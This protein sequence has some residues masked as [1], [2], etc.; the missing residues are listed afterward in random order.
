MIKTYRSIDDVLRSPWADLRTPG[1]KPEQ[2][3]R[4]LKSTRLEDSIYADLRDGDGALDELEAASTSKLKT[5]PALSRDVYQSL[6]SLM[7]RK[8]PEETLSATARKFN[9]NILDHVMEGDDYPTLKAVCEGRELPAYEAA[10]EFTARVA[11]E[12]DGL[13]ADMGGGKGALN[14]LEKLEDARE[15]AEQELSALLDRL[16]SGQGGNDTL[17]QTVVAAANHADS[18]QRQAEAVAKRVDTCMAKNKDAIDAVLTH[19]AHAAKEKAEEVQSVIGA[20]SE[21]P[22]NQGRNALNT[23]LLERVRKNPALLEISKYLGR[24]REIFAQGKKNG[25]AYG[26]GEK[27]SLEL[28][29][30]LSRAIT[31]ELALLAAPETIP[32]FLRKFQQKQLKQYRRREPIYKGAGD[33]ICCLDESSSTKGNPAAWGKAVAMTLLEIAADGGRKFAL[34]HFSGRDS[35]KVDLFLPGAYTAVD[36]LTAAETFLDGGTNFVTPL[37]ESLRLMGEQ[38]FE[39]ADIVFITDGEC[40]LTEE[41]LDVLRQQQTELRF[42]ITGVLLDSDDPDMDFSLKAF[43][44]SIY[45]TSQL[46]GEEIVRE[47]VSARV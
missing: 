37:R 29:S 7:P 3:D 1:K 40:A 4:V 6:Y 11:G 8:A 16:R 32:L 39:N 25:Y 30:D 5:F 9:A 10:G 20:W 27:Y 47:L 14:T 36:K 23:D 34:V 35:F 45:R 31:S 43:C 24:F 44:Q 18:K 17:E 26:R 15:Q 21:D 13:L 46:M 22:G 2:S 33:I 28:G 42:T 38:G 12:L 19:A 41:A